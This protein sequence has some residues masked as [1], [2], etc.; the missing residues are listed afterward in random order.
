MVGVAT[1]VTEA[2]EHI[3]VED[4]FTDTDGVTVLAVIVMGVLVAVVGLA[5]GAVEV[6]ITVTLSPLFKL[7]V[8]KVDEFVPALTPFTC[9]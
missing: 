7:F 3:D 6:M 5:Q 9:H 8:V 1:K 4:G 2:P